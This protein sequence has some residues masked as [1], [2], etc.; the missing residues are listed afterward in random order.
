MGNFYLFI[1]IALRTV[2]MMLITAFRETIKKNN[3]STLAALFLSLSFCWSFCQ[4]CLCIVVPMCVYDIRA[5]NKE[6]EV[7]LV[8][9]RQCAWYSLPLGLSYHSLAITLLDMFWPD[10]QQGH[11]SLFCLGYIFGS[12]RMNNPDSRRQ[13]HNRLCC[14]WDTS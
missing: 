1:V 11:R 4:C 6:E 2:L 12:N 8:A 3:L 5:R 10:N 9:L 13:K 14:Q 7:L